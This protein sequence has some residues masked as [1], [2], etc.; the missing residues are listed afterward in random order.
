MGFEWE[1]VGSD[2]RGFANLM[3]LRKTREK[4]CP[5]SFKRNY[6]VICQMASFNIM[7]RDN[8]IAYCCLEE[9]MFWVLFL[10]K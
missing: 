9:L 3:C 1:D 8:N 6:D 4:S 2:M 7:S 10:K 5:R